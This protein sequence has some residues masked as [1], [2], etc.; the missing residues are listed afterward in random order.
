MEEITL[1][2]AV[3]R[4][5]A[6]RGIICESE[7]RTLKVEAFTVPIPH[8]RFQALLRNRIKECFL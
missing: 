8:Q 2:N 4:G 6:N 7:I 3:D 1:E 5:F